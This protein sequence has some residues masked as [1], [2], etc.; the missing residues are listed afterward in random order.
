MGN[1]VL[2]KVKNSIATITLNRPERKNAI[3]QALLTGLYDSI[4]KIAKT[5][6]IKVGI[7]TGNGNAFCSGIDLDCFATDNLFDPRSD[8][9]DMPEIF[10]SC[11]K[12]IIGAVNGYA[13]T[14][15]FEIALNCDFLIASENAVFADTHAKVGIHP[16][17]GMS[18]LLQQAV[19]QRLAKQFSATCE[20]ISAA[21]AL[22]CGLVNELVPADKL[23]ERVIQIADEI[24]SV[25]YDMML[26]M[27]KLIEAKNK[28]TLIEGMVLEQKGFKSFLKQV[29][30]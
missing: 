27:K 29:R 13:I 25:N 10:E 26:T 11:N 12:P 20:K 23:L 15:G 6:E 21:K 2:F 17:W 5:D 24:C 4:E 18:Q 22:S 3:N 9:K 7:I 8:G 30:R 1:E 28:S 16:G 19:G 14:G